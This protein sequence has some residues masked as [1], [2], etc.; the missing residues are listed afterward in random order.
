MFD[1]LVFN[2]DINRGFGFGRISAPTLDDPEP[3]ADESG[4][5]V[6]PSLGRRMWVGLFLEYGITVVF[7]KYD[8]ETEFSPR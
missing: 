2:P 7:K 6:D 5:E 4:G 8:A 1:A 3:A